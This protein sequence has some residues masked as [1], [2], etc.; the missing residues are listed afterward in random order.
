[1]FKQVLLRY[2]VITVLFSR[3]LFISSCASLITYTLS[4]V[5]RQRER[6]RTHRVWYHLHF[7][8]LCGFWNISY[9]DGA[10]VCIV[11]NMLLEKG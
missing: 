2:I 1:M 6:H 8:I 3:Q 7:Q 4:E 5:L 10:A 11:L 9:R